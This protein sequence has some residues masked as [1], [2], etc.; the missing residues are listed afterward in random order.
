MTVTTA[1]PDLRVENITKKFG[2][3]TAVDNVS[4]TIEE[5]QFATLLGPSGCGKTTTLRIVAGLEQQTEGAVYIRGRRVDRDPPYRR[6]AAMIF[7]D[8]ALFPHMSVAQNIAFGPSLK[9]LPDADI[10]RKVEET[11]ELVGL[12]GYGDRRPHQ[13]SGGQQQ[14][15]A[16][17]RA[18]IN[19]TPIVLSDESLGAL[20]LKMRQEMQIELKRIQQET[21]VTF[22][23]VTHDQEEALTMSDTVV[24]MSEGRVQQIGSPVEVY[25]RP[26]NRFVADFIGESNFIDGQVKSNSAGEIFVDLEGLPVVS[27]YHQASYPPGT[28]VIVSSRPEHLSLSSERTEPGVNA[29]PGTIEDIIYLGSEVKVLVR[30]Q[31]GALIHY[32]RSRGRAVQK[33]LK[34]EQQVYV[35][36]RPEHAMVFP[37]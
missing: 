8:Y 5:G 34:R 16:V 20:D 37:R 1:A 2:D 22:I 30:L 12:H 9:K 29:L 6:E 31:N 33:G 7:Q 15:V 28:P 36:W 14:R 13:L 11:L 27:C 21:G 18:L 17:A 32:K 25:D 4:F 10:Q 26:Q 24:V 19:D 3:V 23:H 35:L